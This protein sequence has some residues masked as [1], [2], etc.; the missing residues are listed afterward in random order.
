MSPGADLIDR[1]A[2]LGEAR[3]A[4]GHRIF[5]AAIPVAQAA[6]ARWCERRKMP[7]SAV[8]SGIG[9]P[10]RSAIA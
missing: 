9:S 8:S 2:A 6:R 7:K 3:R 10:F 5:R 4:G 1:P